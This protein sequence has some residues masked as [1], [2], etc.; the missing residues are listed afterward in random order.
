MGGSIGGGGA[1][2]RPFDDRDNRESDHARA[3]GCTATK[4]EPSHVREKEK[5]APSPH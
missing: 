3:I 4:Q 5:R 1:L 2:F